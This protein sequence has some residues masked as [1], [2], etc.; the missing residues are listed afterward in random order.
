MPSLKSQNQLSKDDLRKLLNKNGQTF[1][2]RPNIKFAH[3][4]TDIVDYLV[5]TD[6][7]YQAFNDEAQG[8]FTL[9]MV[10]KDFD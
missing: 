8:V 10:D 5:N 6:T 3:V 2:P 7:K 4:P 9:H 1:I